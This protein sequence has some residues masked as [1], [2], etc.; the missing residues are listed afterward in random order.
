MT[1]YDFEMD[2]TTWGEL[3][4]FCADESC[5]CVDCVVSGYEIR[6]S[7]QYEL[8]YWARDYDW[9]RVRDILDNVPE[10]NDDWY[11]DNGPGEWDLAD[12]DDFD[13]FKRQVLEWGDE[14]EIWETE[15]VLEDEED[16]VEQED[17]LSFDEIFFRKELIEGA[18]AVMTE[19]R[20]EQTMRQDQ[21]KASFLN[22]IGG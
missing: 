13:D 11:I 17:E 22:L 10:D 20:H 8:P 6:D 21:E 5:D 3:K 9:E 1:R 14:V 16:E 12:S 15:D 18:A 7:I 19:I 2:V 4:D